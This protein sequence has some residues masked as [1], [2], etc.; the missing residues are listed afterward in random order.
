MKFEVK[1]YGNKKEILKFPDH[2]VA[3]AV[4][5]DDSGVVVDENGKKILK[6]GTLVGGGVIKDPQA[7]VST[8]N[9]AETE[10][11][12]MNDVDLTYGPAPGA[13]I[14]HGFVDLSKIPE[15]PAIDVDLP[16]ISFIK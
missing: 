4:M 1:E 15:E 2:Y 11:V 13:M 6:A 12:L 10:G 9:G 16:Q 8:V 5:V 14:I 7:K 3:I